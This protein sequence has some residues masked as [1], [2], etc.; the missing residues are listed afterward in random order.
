MGQTPEETHPMLLICTASDGHNLQLAQTLL[1]VAEDLNIDAKILDLTTIDLPLFTPAREKKKGRPAALDL[2]EPLF[3]EAR[4]LAICSPEYN[5]SI[6][7]VFTNT[8]A[9][10]SRKTSDFRRLFNGKPVMLA[11]H[12]GGHGQKMLMAIRVQL[13]HLG[14]TV[15]GHDIAT[16]KDKPLNRESVRSFLI[17]MGQM[18]EQTGAA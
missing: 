12:S 14:C 7:P 1:S 8:L 10:V 3:G 15:I 5:G 2:V 6:P 18:I 9:W 11:T 17:L 4:G 16:N 13:S